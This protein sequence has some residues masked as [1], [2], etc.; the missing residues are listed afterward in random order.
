[1]FFCLLFW[2]MCLRTK[3]EPQE[4]S[5]TK[6]FK[7][8]VL[9]AVGELRRERQLNGSACVLPV[10]RYSWAK[11][12]RGQQEAHRLWKRENNGHMLKKQSDK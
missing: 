11:R 10:Q 6:L 1:M 2:L 7:L 12:P 8:I 9:P 3:T 4:F 5:K